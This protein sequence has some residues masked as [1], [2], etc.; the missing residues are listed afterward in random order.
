M[1]A[2]AEVPAAVRPETEWPYR[3][4]V[5]PL[6]SLRV[7]EGYQRPPTTFVDEVA[8]DWKPHLV[9]TIFVSERSVDDHVIVD[10]QTRWRA[11]LKRGDVTNLPALVYFD[12][13][14][15]EEAKLMADLAKKR[16][17]IRTYDQF[18]ASLFGK[19]PEAVAIARL[20]K[21]HGGLDLRAHKTFSDAPPITALQQAYRRGVLPDVLHVISESWGS[22]TEGALSNQTLR[23]LTHFLTHQES[24]DL[25]RLIDRLQRVDPMSLPA[26]AR[27]LQTSKE[28]RGSLAPY[29][30]EILLTEYVRRAR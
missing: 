11:A 9:G 29:T 10:G 19:D 22:A 28:G 25:E 17:Q 14:P 16:R 8:D 30:A 12:L 20:A 18:R 6:E 4:E 26:R 15:E 24:V 21:K 13:T 2:L 5:L 23:G 27:G 7:D 3:F 1:A